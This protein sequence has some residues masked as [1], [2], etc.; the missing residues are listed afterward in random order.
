MP[1]LILSSRTKNAKRNAISGI[2]K[3][4]IGMGLSFAV[5][6]A[7][8]YVLGTQ[9][10][11]LNGLF[12]AILQVL[13]ITDLGFSTAVTVVLYKPIAEDNVEQ[14][15]SIIAY[16]KRIYRIV[17]FIIFCGG[18]CVLPYL[19]YLVKD[20]YPSDV[21]IYILF[22]IYLLNAVTSYFLF[23]YKGTLLT[24]LQRDDIVSNVYSFSSIGIKTL[25]IVLLIIFHNYYAFIVVLPLGSVLNNLLIEFF[26]RKHFKYLKASGIISK[27]KKEEILK[28]VKA[29]FLSR[30]SDVARNSFDDI[31]ISSFIGLSLVAAYDNY[32]YIFTSIAGMM[33]ILLHSVRASIGNSIV[34]ETVEKNQKDLHIFTFLYMSVG[35]FCFTCLLCLY[36]P[37]MQIWMGDKE[38]MILSNLNMILFCL[39][40]YIYC[41]VYTKCAYLEARGLFHECR[42][43]YIF[44]ALSNLVL[45][46][47]FGY[48]LGITGV[49]LATIITLFGFNFVGG[50]IVLYKYYFKNG[51]RTFFFQHLAYAVVACL[52]T[53][54]IYFALKLIPIGGIGGFAIKGASCI[55]LSAVLYFLVYF[56]TRAFKNSL[57][58]I[59]R[60][61]GIK[62]KHQID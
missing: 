20:S 32:Y 1:K 5:R 10:Q 60:L 21:N 55:I 42:Y 23:A 16:L 36:Q 3:H 30:L 17:G 45:N 28:Q 62:T 47:L 8:I 50:T 34:K 13:N 7:I 9:Y 43:L 41:M 53:A 4:L 33:G 18:L 51:I 59:K 52:V 24:A 2:A 48:F 26:S 14:V 56:R 46:I 44:E 29:V 31:I 15:C 54:L 40:F 11:G 49:L 25:Q 27:E 38:N 58:Y 22:I 61:L 6:T 19:N 12:T 37:F 35:S 39:Y 57:P